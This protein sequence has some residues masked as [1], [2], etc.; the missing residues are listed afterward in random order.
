MHGTRRR[1]VRRII[2]REVVIAGIDHAA[3]ADE[4]GDAEIGRDSAGEDSWGG[5]CEGEEDK[6][7]EDEEVHFDVW[8][9][10]DV[11]VRMDCE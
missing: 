5:G 7:K 8:M 4:I 1:P 11:L 3:V 9:M 10:V 2:N 6:G